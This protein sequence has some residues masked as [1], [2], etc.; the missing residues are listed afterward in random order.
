AAVCTRLQALARSL[1]EP[2]RRPR[3]ATMPTASAP[4]ASASTR[5][6]A[7][8]DLWDDFEAALPP[9]WEPQGGAVDTQPASGRVAVVWGPH[10][11]PG[12]SLVAAALAAGL[13]GETILVDADIEA[14][15]LTQLLGLPEESSALATAARL[16]ARGRLDAE[17]LERILIPITA[18]RH[19]LTGLGRSG[20]WR[21]LPPA[22][23]P[24][25]WDRCRGAA[26]WTVVDI[27]GGRVDDA[28]DD[29]TLEP[30]R[31]AVSVELLRNADVV[32]IVGAGD[33][34]GVRRLLQLMDDLSEDI[35]P[36][37]RIE[38]VVNRVRASAA[39]PSPQRAVREALARFGGV[40]DIVVLPEDGATAD[41]CLMEGRSIT[42]AAP[43]SPLGWALAEL[44]DRI[45]PDSRAV[46]AAGRAARG[47]RWQRVASRFGSRRPDASAATAPAQT[48]SDDGSPDRAVGAPTP[49]PPPPPEAGAD[50]DARTDRR[51][52]RHRM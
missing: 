36:A 2:T 48:T 47:Q 50:S 32:V 18:G 4:T 26:R 37:G 9:A 8:T 14:P 24:E 21:E 45:D 33:P 22:A 35:Q 51:G 29:F 40:E 42:E 6:P 34:V 44:I 46:A 38:V 23:M 7:G 43:A 25:V 5:M 13:P 3:S 41:R 39:G 20:R 27:A 1:D 12:R 31:G 17:A 49:A 15:C 30:G 16:A 10:G 11:A 52:G 28:V 19:L